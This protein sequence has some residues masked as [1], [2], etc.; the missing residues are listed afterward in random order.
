[1][2]GSRGIYHDGWKAV[3]FKPLGRMYDDGLDPD[4]PFEDD[5]WELYH[6][7]EDHSECDDLAASEPEKLAEL[8]DIWWREARAHDVLPLD[9]RPI[10]SLMFPRRAWTDRGRYVFFPDGAVV[11]E[12]VTVNV[13]NRPHSIAASVAIEESHADAVEGVLLAMGNVLGGFSFHVIDG[14]LRYVH[15]HLGKVTDEV[16]SSV[17]LTPGDHELRYVYDTAGDFRGTG[18]L[19][20]DG[21]VVGEGP[22]ENVTPVRYSITGGGITCGWEQGPPVGSGYDAPFRFTGR[23]HRVVVTTTGV[24]HRD[25]DAEFEAIM[26]EQ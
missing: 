3:T 21:Q 5:V 23:L 10:A 7:A 14:C 19:L 4:A 6:V 8:I 12:T 13:R 26:S 18:T 11:P 22:I 17:R 1:M 24:G 9:N 2:F 16:A 15:N 25:P 20:I